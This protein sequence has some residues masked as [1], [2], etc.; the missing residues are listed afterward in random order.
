MVDVSSI[1]PDEPD[2][3]RLDDPWDVEALRANPA[4]PTSVEK[5]LTGL[6]VRK[7]SKDVFIRVHPSPDYSLDAPLLFHTPEGQ[8]GE[9]MYWVAPS[10]RHIMGEYKLE[11]KATRLYLAVTEFGD[12]FFWYVKLPGERGGREWADSAINLAEQAKGAWLR[13]ISN[14]NAGRYEAWPAEVQMPEP[15]WSDRSLT[16]LIKLAFRD[17]MIDSLDHEI[18][19]KL[20]GAA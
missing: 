17:R 15:K 14:T 10:L 2:G 11:L 4:T 6:S 13:V 12:S 7:P 3:K 1:P 16:E 9:R 18:I 20:R 8:I 5:L 19:R